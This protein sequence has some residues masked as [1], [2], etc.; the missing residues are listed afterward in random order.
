MLKDFFTNHKDIM[1]ELAL[2]AA[3]IMCAAVAVCPSL[4]ECLVTTFKPYGNV[5]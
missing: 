1:I 2:L 3:V 4:A 5:Y